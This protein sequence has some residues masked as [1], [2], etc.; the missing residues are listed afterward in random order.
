[1]W[2]GVDSDV[3]LFASGDVLDDDGE[4]AGGQSLG[5][6]AG[7]RQRRLC[8]EE[9]ALQEGPGGPAA[10]AFRGVARRNSWLL[11]SGFRVCVWV[12]PQGS[13][14]LGSGFRVW[15]RSGLQGPAAAG[16]SQDAF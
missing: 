16:I 11:G 2:A 12:G 3:A 4:W 8:D 14:L 6:E 9:R 7:V 10:A 13:Q 1:M 5:A 15:V